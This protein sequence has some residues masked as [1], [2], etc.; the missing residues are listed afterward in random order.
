MQVGEYVE[1]RTGD[2]YEVTN[3]GERFCVLQS[4]DMLL[5]AYVK[6]VDKWVR[7]VVA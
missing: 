6:N 3:V 5:V 1:S 7:I 4:D 2:V